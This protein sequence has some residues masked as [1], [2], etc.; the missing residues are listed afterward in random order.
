VLVELNGVIAAFC[1]F[2]IGLKEP[3][4]LV[5]VVIAHFVSVKT[6]TSTAW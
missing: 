1:P 3:A 4:L 6:T 2:R 5:G